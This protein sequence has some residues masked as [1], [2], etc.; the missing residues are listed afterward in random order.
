MAPD[1]HVP[2]PL[3]IRLGRP[4][5]YSLLHIPAPGIQ[6]LCGYPTSRGA[7][8]MDLHFLESHERGSR[9]KGAYESAP[10]S[11]ETGPMWKTGIQE[12][13]VS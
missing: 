5:S 8:G 4:G 7:E 2:I 12:G 9:G 3:S 1:S 10:R 11:T 13:F 6:V